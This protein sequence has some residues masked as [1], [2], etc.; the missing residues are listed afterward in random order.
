[1]ANNTRIF[2]DLDL[3]F[4]KHP[5]T[6]DLS[7]KFDENAIN[8]SLRNLILTRNYE[9]PFHSEIGSQVRAVLFEPANP[10]TAIKLKRS[11]EDVVTNFEPRVVL[12][13][14]DVIDQSDN[15]A[16]TI[17]ITYRIVNSTRPI[18]LDLVLERTR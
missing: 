18:K 6:H 2:S 15:N 16:Y 3:G 12:L 14:V 13:S 8:Q 5:V 4:T 1:M 17:T 11:I 9:R 10:L 7:R